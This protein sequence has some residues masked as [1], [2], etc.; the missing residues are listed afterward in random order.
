MNNN[1]REKQS[2]AVRV[3]PEMANWMHSQNDERKQLIQK[4][5][6]AAKARFA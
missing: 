2:I 6:E 3:T 5:V 4:Q 1:S